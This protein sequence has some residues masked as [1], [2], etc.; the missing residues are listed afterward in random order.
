M[1]I[2]LIL[3]WL[4]FGLLAALW[5]REIDGPPIEMW[6]FLC[7]IL[8]GL[9]MFGIVFCGQIFKDWYV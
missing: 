3:L 6:I 7:Y 2:A 1:L 8:G 4:L 9:L 5:I